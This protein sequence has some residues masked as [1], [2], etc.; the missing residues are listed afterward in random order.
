MRDILR[1]LATNT[2]KLVNTQ[3][4]KSLTGNGELIKELLN[5]GNEE[6]STKF[7]LAATDLDI[8]TDNFTLDELRKAINKMKPNKSPGTDFVVTVETLKYGRNELHNA[9]LDRHYSVLNDLGVPY[10]W[11]E[12]IIV[13]TPKKA[14]KGMKDLH[15]IS[16]MSITAKVYNRMLLNP[17][18]DPIDKLL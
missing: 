10:Q 16:L 2:A 14:S 4:G 3:N 8:C 6:G 11:T 15:G 12:C 9:V 7:P 17:I 1:T 18:Y 5:G 13:S